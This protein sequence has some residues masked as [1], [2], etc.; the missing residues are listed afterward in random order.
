M[1]NEIN[2]VEKI[3]LHS[4]NSNEY[5]FNEINNIEKICLYSLNSNEYFFIVNADNNVYISTLYNFKYH[6]IGYG[7]SVLRKNLNEHL[8]TSRYICEVSNLEFLKINNY[9]LLIDNKGLLKF[10]SKNYPEELL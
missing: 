5:F 1:N 3:C 2:N 10:L 4:L 7:Y 9:A 6:A 8:L